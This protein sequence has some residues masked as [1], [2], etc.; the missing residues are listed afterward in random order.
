MV[1]HSSNEA[2]IANGRQNL[3]SKN[4]LTTYDL[5]YIIPSHEVEGSFSPTCD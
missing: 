1:C 2:Y 3:V 4:S 5:S